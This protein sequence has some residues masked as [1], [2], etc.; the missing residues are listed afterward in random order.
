[1]AWFWAVV[2]ALAIACVIAGGF[3]LVGPVALVVGGLLVL[4]LS[5]LVNRKGGGA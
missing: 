1:M 5:A 4:V 3:M 2:E